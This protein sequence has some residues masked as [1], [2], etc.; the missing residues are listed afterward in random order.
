MP[1]FYLLEFG[2]PLVRQIVLI[3]HLFAFAFAIVL[4]ARGDVAMLRGEYLCGVRDLKTDANITAVL[5]LVLWG[6]GLG[7]IGMGVGFDL[8]AVL[9]NG[10][11]LAKLTVVLILTLNG[12]FLHFYAFP[13]MSGSGAGARESANEIRLFICCLL[14]ALSSVSWI[15][16]S[17]F[18][19]ARIIA[20]MASFSHFMEFYG[21]ALVCGVVVGLMVVRPLL[22]RQLLNAKTDAGCLINMVSVG[23]K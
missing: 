18:G 19:A 23:T 6:T 4:V 10:K 7:L 15:C 12:I 1:D 17:V 21:A 11:I 5:L 20:P 9:T 13:L 8:A 3:V 14:G 16:A 2:M 22:R